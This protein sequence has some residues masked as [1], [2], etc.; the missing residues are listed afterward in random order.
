ML[1]AHTPAARHFEAAAVLCDEGEVVIRLIDGSGRPL[2]LTMG[3]RSAG[4]L[5]AMLAA[6]RAAHRA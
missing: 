3:T 4:E 1:Q 5:A 6:S 2:E